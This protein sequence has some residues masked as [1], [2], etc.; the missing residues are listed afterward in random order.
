MKGIVKGATEAEC[1]VPGGEIGDAAE[2]IKGL[3]EGK[4]FDMIV[5]SIGEV[6][7]EKIIFGRNIKPG[8]S[9][10]G[11][12]SFGLHSNGISLARKILLKQWG[13]KYEPQDVPDGLDR[14]IVYEVLE[15]TR[16]YVKPL[17]RVAD[18]I[19]V[20][21]A[22]HITGDAY[23]KF[24]N[25]ARFSK[26]IGFE[27]DNFDPQPIFGLIQKTALELGGRITDE[28]MFKTFN[29][30]WGFAIVVD[31]KDMDKT[32]EILETNEAHAEQIGEIRHR[33]GIEIL[34]KKRKIVLR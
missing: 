26:G 13:G 34:Y 3:V 16:I 10:I 19:E 21:A 11:L 4:G 24:N 18:E 6:T 25:L 22:V 2:I 5:S 17:L 27:F 9:I 33:E 14:G 8:D 30:G 20:K 15:P 32:V 28:E 29:M 7:K 1:V 12:R 23:A 31:K